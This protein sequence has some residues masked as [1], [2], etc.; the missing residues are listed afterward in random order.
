[1]HERSYGTNSSFVRNVL[2]FRGHDQLKD[3]ANSRVTKN[4]QKE[5]KER[6]LLAR[7]TVHVIHEKRTQ[8]VAPHGKTKQETQNRQRIG[9][10][11][12]GNT[13]RSIVAN[14]RIKFTLEKNHGEIHTSPIRFNG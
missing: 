13:C 3:R 7:S 9:G 12:C 14:V 4:V 5:R 6:S 11:H 1:M 10:Q 2:A 8:S